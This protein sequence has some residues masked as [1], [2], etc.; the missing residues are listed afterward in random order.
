[1]CCFTCHQGVQCD[2]HLQAAFGHSTAGRSWNATPWGR[3][4]QISQVFVWYNN[5]ISLVTFSITD[6]YHHNALLMKKFQY[7]VMIVKHQITWTNCKIVNR[8][9]FILE[10][11]FDEVRQ[12]LIYF[13]KWPQSFVFEMW[14]MYTCANSA[15]QDV[16]CLF[17][18]S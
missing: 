6:Q 8:L 13:V 12:L 3:C 1:M 7:T 15:I 9:F 10:N 11:N 18:L 14:Y 2:I 17:Q 5:S 16:L 4:S